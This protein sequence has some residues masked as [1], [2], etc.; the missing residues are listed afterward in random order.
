MASFNISIAFCG[1][2][3]ANGVYISMRDAMTEN[4]LKHSVTDKSGAKLRLP[5][6]KFTFSGYL[7]RNKVLDNVYLIVSK[8]IP[9]PEVMVSESAGRA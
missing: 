9:T 3:D 2:I 4:G 7:S 8:F 5:R 6:D 1:E